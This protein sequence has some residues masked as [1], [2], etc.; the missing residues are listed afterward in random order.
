MVS[1]QRYV[2]IFFQWVLLPASLAIA[3]TPRDAALIEVAAR[4]DNDSAR[5][6]IKDG[7]GITARDAGGRSAPAHPP[8][9][10]T[11]ISGTR[12]CRVH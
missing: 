5:G 9:R 11:R 12:R 6:L 1:L 4:G 3:Q 2:A 8:L 7:A 10:T